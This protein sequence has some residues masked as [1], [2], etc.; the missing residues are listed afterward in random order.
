MDAGS[1]KPDRRQETGR[2]GESI[3]ADYLRLVGFEVI[4]RNLRVDQ[5]EIDLLACERD[6]LVFVEVRLRRS[7]RY[8]GALESVTT[9][10]HARLRSAMRIEVQRRGWCGAYRLDLLAIDLKPAGEGLELE[11]YRGL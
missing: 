6:C 9:R 11:H 10:K 8:G 4:E 2:L 3:G 7:R 5:K 1:P